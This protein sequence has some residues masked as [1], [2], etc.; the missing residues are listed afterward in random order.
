M[1]DVLSQQVTLQYLPGVNN[2]SPPINY[3]V[4]Q[5]TLGGLTKYTF[6]GYSVVNGAPVSVSPNGFTQV[7]YLYVINGDT[8]NPVNV[9]FTPLNQALPTTVSVA[10]G[11]QFGGMFT[12]AAAS[13]VVLT[14]AVAGQT[15]GVT[16]LLAGI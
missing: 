12:L 4:P 2:L 9:T 7:Q 1:A 8:T 6:S 14:Q 3:A 5:V 11:G 15:S 16:A 13:S 10:A